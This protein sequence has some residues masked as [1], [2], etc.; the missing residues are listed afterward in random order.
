MRKLRRGWVKEETLIAAA[1]RK[2]RA[3]TVEASRAGEWQRAEALAA[4]GKA[5]EVAYPGETVRVMEA[6]V[7]K[8]SGRRA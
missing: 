5:L 1:Y 6:R 8:V 4:A 3:D 2:V 7:S